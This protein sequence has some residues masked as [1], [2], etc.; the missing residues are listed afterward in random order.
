MGTWITVELRFTG[1]ATGGGQIWVNGVTQP[2]WTISGNFA[3]T[4]PYQRLQLWNDALGTAD[5]DDVV[6]GT[7]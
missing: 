1:T 7:P 4:A 2:A 6:V 5:F 3:T